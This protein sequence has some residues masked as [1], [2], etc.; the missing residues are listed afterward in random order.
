MKKP[1]LLSVLFAV[2]A[3]PVVAATNATGEVAACTGKVDETA[4]VSL[5]LGLHHVA[6]VCFPKNLD[7]IAVG[8]RSIDVQ[9]AGARRDVLFV[10]NSSAFGVPS[11]TNIIAYGKSGK[12]YELEVKTAA[13]AEHKQFAAPQNSQARSTRQVG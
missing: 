12:R 4:S 11:T 7:S 13:P 10:A 6:D 2:L 1:S 9:R 5:S 3:A 8:S